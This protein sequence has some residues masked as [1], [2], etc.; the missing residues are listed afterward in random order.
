MMR[1]GL[2][3]S[4]YFM[5]TLI[6]CAQ[7]SIPDKELQIA[8]AV[9]ATNAE[10][11]RAGASVFGYDQDGDRV[12][13][14]EGTNNLICSSDDPNRSGFQCVC[15]HK[16]LEPFMARGRSLRAEGLSSGEIFEIREKEAK[17]G[18]LQMPKQPT[19]LH[20]LEGGEDASYDV[21]SG[22]IMNANY[23]YVV[24]IPWATAASTG[25]PDKPHIPGGPWI[26][27]PG[28]HRAHIMITPPVKE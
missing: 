1:F 25:L 12:L 27:D 6:S 9:L 20:L 8:A 18:Q 14:R 21:A 7:E 23:R 5:I 4:M 19:T 24:Y 26:M 3:F 16:D 17:A 15:Y 2:L 10:G 28:T 11:D 13:L 22:Q